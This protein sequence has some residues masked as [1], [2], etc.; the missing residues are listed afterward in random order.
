MSTPTVLELSPLLEALPPNGKT[1]DDKFIVDN[2][3]IILTIIKKVK[4][5]YELGGPSARAYHCFCS[6][7]QQGVFLLLPGWDASV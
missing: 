2:A 4:Y 1:T 6:M 7:K 5:A 3:K